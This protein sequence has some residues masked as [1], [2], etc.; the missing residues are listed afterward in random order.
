MLGRVNREETEQEKIDRTLNIIYEFERAAETRHKTWREN[1]ISRGYS[2]EDIAQESR[3][4]LEQI[5]AGTFPD[6][7]IHG[8]EIIPIH[9]L[10]ELPIVEPHN[11]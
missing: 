1:L 5:K 4:I 11:N 9:R 2:E 7:K 10:P 3:N 8:L 6:D